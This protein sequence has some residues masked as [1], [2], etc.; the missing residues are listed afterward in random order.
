MGVRVREIKP[1]PIKPFPVKS[2]TPPI[3]PGYE[4]I[5]IEIDVSLLDR[6]G[7]W[8]FQAYEGVK[9]GTRIGFALIKAAIKVD[10][11]FRSEGKM[12]EKWY[13]SRRMWAMVLGV[14]VTI[15]GVFK[16][17]VP[18]AVVTAGPDILVTIAT[19]IATLIS[20]VLAAWSWFK[21]KEGK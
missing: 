21:P 8:A 2:P 15:L 11:F 6:A 5:Q 4:R 18:D 13:E 19:G 3:L 7:L 12:Q 16:V 17:A 9:I 1:R 14:I 20:S 10:E